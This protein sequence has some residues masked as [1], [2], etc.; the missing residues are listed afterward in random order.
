MF[1]LMEDRF[2]MSNLSKN[3][4]SASENFRIVIENM[5]CTYKNNLISHA[6]LLIVQQ[7]NKLSSY[8]SR[9]TDFKELYEQV[10]ESI[11]IENDKTGFDDLESLIGKIKNNTELFSLIYD[12]TG[13][14]KVLLD[15][16]KYNEFVMSKTVSNLEKLYAM[17]ERLNT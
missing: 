13:D 17:E 14:E 1:F 6:N 12:I 9:I 4:K 10:S 3:L 7:Q 5:V 11:L 8:R 16:Q 15:Y 2:V